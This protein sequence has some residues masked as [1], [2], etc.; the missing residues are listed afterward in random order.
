M[1]KISYQSSVASDPLRSS[2][3]PSRIGRHERPITDHRSPITRCSF[4]LIELLVVIAIISILAALLMP[5]LK[6][7]RET[8]KV[9]VCTNNLR[10]LYFA[11]MQYANDNN[12]YP[13]LNCD[14]TTT[15]WQQGSYPI[16]W[17]YLL[18]PY[19]G[20]KGTGESYVNDN[21]NHGSLEIR[22]GYSAVANRCYKTSSDMSTRF[23][24]P[25]WCPATNKQYA[26]PNAGTY[27]CWG[28]VAIDYAINSY[29]TS[30]VQ[31]D[32]SWHPAF[33]Q[34]LR[35]G[36]HTKTEKSK[37][38]FIGD[39]YG[40]FYR[41]YLT[42]SNRHFSTGPTDN[43]SGRL[44]CVFWDGHVEN[45]TFIGTQNPVSAGD[46]NVQTGYN[47]TVRPGFKYYIIPN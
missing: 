25:L 17:P 43:T 9:I 15:W 6:H 14:Y 46:G 16:T 23:P 33:G 8:A 19:L 1:R 3:D 44:N 11:S 27:G 36:E 47:E 41:L 34:A 39:S 32:G 21:F 35:V 30:W 12:D 29:I 37:L 31:S 26:W 42:P 13:P 22:V 40:F 24:G 4:T 45:L 5:A 2:R 7:A 28:D 10:Q 38:L 20:Y 18:I